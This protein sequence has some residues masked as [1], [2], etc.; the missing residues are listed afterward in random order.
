MTFRTSVF[1]RLLLDFDTYRGVDSLGVFHLFLKK[2]A[3]I[4]DPKLSIIFHRLICL[5]SFTECWRSANVTAIPKGAPSSHRENYRLISITLIQ[6]KVFEMLVSHKFS[7]FCEKYGLLP[8][9]QFPYRKGM[10]CTD[11]QLTISY[12]LQKCLDAGMESYIFQL[13]FSAAFD[14]VSHR[15]LLFKLKSIGVGAINL[16]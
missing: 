12:H 8:A 10:G 7:S 14:R 2:V 13:D 3:D 5:G 16:Y 6:S 9:A 1:L 15:R 4:I 11:A